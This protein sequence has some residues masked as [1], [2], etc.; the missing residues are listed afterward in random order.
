MFKKYLRLFDD[1]HYATQQ[2][3][4]F[5]LNQWKWFLNLYQ[6]IFRPIDKCIFQWYFDAGNYFT[7]LSLKE[8][9]NIGIY[10]LLKM[11]I[12]IDTKKVN[13]YL[14]HNV[15][16]KKEYS[17][18]GLFQFIGEKGLTNILTSDN[19]ALGFPNRA[20]K[21]GH[22]RLGWEEIGSMQFIAYASD[23]VK[24]SFSDDTYHFD[25]VQEFPQNINELTSATESLFSLRVYKDSDFLNWRKSK[26][27]TQYD[28]Y[29][30]KEK[31]SKNLVGYLVLKEYTEKNE[32]RLHLVDFLFKNTD[33]L[34]SLIVFVRKY[35]EN[36]YYDMLNTWIAADSVY[37]DFFL[38][39]GFFV[40]DDIPVYPII[41]FQKE[42]RFNFDNI[43]RNKIFF[44]LFDNDVF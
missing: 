11:N 39:Q 36:N 42:Q 17:G 20:S 12:S 2:Y 30:I 40:Q 5:S 41:L 19:L 28:I 13:A 7:V 44:T 31:E 15:G 43:D 16:I 8:D 35:Y 29:L 6:D 3:K 21:K 23:N 33:V 38:K 18:K 26:P 4:Y 37:K 27:S 25:K 14:C 32:R 22:M 1:A 10:G 24:E 9:S 34:N